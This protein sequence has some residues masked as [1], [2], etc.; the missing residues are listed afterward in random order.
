MPTVS[1]KDVELIDAEVAKCFYCSELYYQ[2][3]QDELERDFTALRKAV[4][5][6]PYEASLKGGG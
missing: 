3:L 6:T 2:A 1:E 4:E 5:G